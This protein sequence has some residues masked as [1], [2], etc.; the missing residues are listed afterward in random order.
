MRERFVIWVGVMLQWGR[1]FIVAE[2]SASSLTIQYL[3]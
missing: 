3:R 1:N 2:T